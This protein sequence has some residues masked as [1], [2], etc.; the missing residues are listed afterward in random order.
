MF[1]WEK[2]DCDRF[3]MQL[4]KHLVM[5]IYSCCPFPVFHIPQIKNRHAN[6]T[7]SPAPRSH[8]S[9]SV[10]TASL[11]GAPKALLAL[12][13]DWLSGLHLEAM[14]IKSLLLCSDFWHGVITDESA[15]PRGGTTFFICLVSR[16]FLALSLYPI[17]RAILCSVPSHRPGEGWQRR[18]TETFEFDCQHPK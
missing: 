15:L 8:F 13:Q 16:F 1:R 14:L 2:A 5:G 12:T 3:L 6:F 10:S 11:F 17:Q 9:D 18:H 4:M 7:T